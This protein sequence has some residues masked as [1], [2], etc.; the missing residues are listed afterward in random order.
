M[1]SGDKLIPRLGELNQAIDAAYSDLIHRLGFSC[2]GCDGV[3]CCTVD[4]VLHTYA[5]M[6]YVRRGF[7][8]LPANVKAPVL[9]RAEKM[10]KA[11]EADPTGDAYRNSVCALNIEGLCAIYEHRPM[12]C[13]LAGVPHEF[14]RPDGRVLQSGGCVPYQE[15]VEPKFPAV[16]LDRTPFYVHMAQIEIEL[17][18][19]FGRRA[20]PRTVA[21]TIVL[22][23]FQ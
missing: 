20:E 22:E 18:K 2:R 5:E 19:T 3:K 14:K 16:K 17:V 12:I 4:L 23:D 10:V 6:L 11:K 1:L 13:R 9:A 15:S 21:E 7:N 8:A